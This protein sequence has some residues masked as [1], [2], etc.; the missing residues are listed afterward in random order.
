MASTDA[1]ENRK[2]KRNTSGRDA[3]SHR[4]AKKIKIAKTTRPRLKAN[5]Q[6]SAISARFGTTTTENED[7]NGSN[8][9]TLEPTNA[10]A[11]STETKAK[12][13]RE[14]L[15]RGDETAS[16]IQNH[17]KQGKKREVVAEHPGSD[18]A[19]AVHS[20]DVS[21]RK[22]PVWA[23]SSPSGGRFLDIDPV[24]SNDEKYV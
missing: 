18:G 16:D 15:K 6:D 4:H 14:R 12:K 11:S 13:R 24:I 20:K 5:S 7:S 3:N 10:N 19:I 22:G 8:K 17:K 2:R 23:I 21:G 9:Q 1:Q